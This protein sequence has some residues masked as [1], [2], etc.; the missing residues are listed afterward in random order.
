[1]NKNFVLIFLIFFALIYWM[2]LTFVRA[3][4]EDLHLGLIEYEIACLP[5]H[6]INAQGDGL[7]AKKLE[8]PPSDL[9]RISLLNGGVFPLDRV[10]EII[11][12]RKQVAAHGQRKMPVWGDRY[13]IR[14]SPDEDATIIERRARGRIE[15]LIEYLISIQ[16]N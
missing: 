5:C 2:S 6:G 16:N 7:M 8:V 12:G 14:L 1:M 9:T 15:A 13:R 3:L 11:D 4:A 10:Y